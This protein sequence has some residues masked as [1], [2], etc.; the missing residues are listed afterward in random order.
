MNANHAVLETGK[1]KE[2]S[3]NVSGAGLALPTSSFQ[4]SETDFGLLTSKT[5]T[6]Y[7]L[8]QATT[9]MTMGCGSLLET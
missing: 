9:L 8:F 2:T 6:E 1:D 7:V 3:P 5:V 4:P